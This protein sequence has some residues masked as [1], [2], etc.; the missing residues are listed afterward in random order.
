MIRITTKSNEEYF[1]S[2]FTSLD[3]ALGY[4]SNLKPSD[5]FYVDDYFDKRAKIKKS[6][7]KAIG[8][9]AEEE[10]VNGGD[11]DRKLKAWPTVDT[12]DV[13]PNLIHINALRK[14]NK[15][16]NLSDYQNHMTLK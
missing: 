6:E 4:I 7:I 2:D 13:N 8:L 9:P 1:S 5:S 3:D 14:S 15:I 16:I 10:V 12:I 11:I